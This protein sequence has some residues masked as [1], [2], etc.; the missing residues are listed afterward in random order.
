[1]NDQDRFEYEVT[2]EQYEF[3]HKDVD[4]IAEMS[5]NQCVGRKEP[6]ML[7]SLMYQS[8]LTAGQRELF[9]KL[10]QSSLDQH[11]TGVRKYVKGKLVS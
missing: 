5:D 6:S 1:M 10:V 4:L 11:V 3:T 7:Y 9:V 8:Q 2:R